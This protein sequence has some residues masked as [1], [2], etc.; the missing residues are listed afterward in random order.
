MAFKPYVLAFDGTLWGCHVHE[1]MTGG[2]IINLNPCPGLVWA[3]FATIV[4]CRRSVTHSDYSNIK[5]KHFP[6]KFNSISSDRLLGFFLTSKHQ[7]VFIMD[8][9]ITNS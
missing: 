4:S 8:E 3:F 6:R 1:L 5:T 2:G 7:V 9:T